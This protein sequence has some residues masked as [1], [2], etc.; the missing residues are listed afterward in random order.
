MEEKHQSFSM[1]E[2]NDYSSMEDHLVDD[3]E[4]SKDDEWNLFVKIQINKLE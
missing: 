1:E 4:F 2:E 3:H